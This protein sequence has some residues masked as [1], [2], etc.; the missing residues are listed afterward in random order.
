MKRS[1]LFFV[2]LVALSN[3]AGCDSGGGGGSSYNPNGTWSMQLIVAND[4]C[5]VYEGKEF[6]VGSVHQVRAAINQSGNQI[7]MRSET[8]GQTLTGTYSDGVMNVGAVYVGGESS[9][10]NLAFI[11]NDVMQ[12]DGF[13]LFPDGCRVNYDITLTRISHEILF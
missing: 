8:S 11:S 12:G 2:L 7:T 10:V 6:Q 5:G 13:D 3:I 1:T 4:P 9:E